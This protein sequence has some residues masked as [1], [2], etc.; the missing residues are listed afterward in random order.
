[1]RISPP[2]PQLQGSPTVYDSIVQ[3]A[4]GLYHHSLKVMLPLIS[5]SSGY[6]LFLLNSPAEAYT[7]T[8]DTFEPQC[9]Q[10]SVL[11]WLR[12]Q[13]VTWLLTGLFSDVERLKPD[14]LFSSDFLAGAM[15]S[16][17]RSGIVKRHVHVTMD[18]AF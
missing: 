7:L 13:K 6:A 15:Y 18:S 11:D 4:C 10:G 12:E 3:S 14:S 17:D 5:W 9:L 16:A 8:A 2:Y 1:M